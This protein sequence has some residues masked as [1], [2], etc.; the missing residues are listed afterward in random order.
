MA[1]LLLITHHA[2]VDPVDRDGRTPLHVAAYH[3]HGTVAR[4]L[5]EYG[6]PLGAPDGHGRT[7]LE[8]ALWAGKSEVVRLIQA[9]QAGTSAWGV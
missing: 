2:P 8:A 7:P 9:H 1:R 4:L 3:G 5:L 6:P